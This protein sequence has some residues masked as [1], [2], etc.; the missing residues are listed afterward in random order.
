MG[1]SLLADCEIHLQAKISKI[2]QPSAIEL[3]SKVMQVAIGFL[4]ATPGAQRVHE[5]IFHALH[6]GDG[7]LANVTMYF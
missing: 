4:G 6:I 5:S 1:W 2:F 7:F 3:L